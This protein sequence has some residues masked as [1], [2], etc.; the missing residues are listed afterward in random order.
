MPLPKQITLLKIAYD[1]TSILA[2]KTHDV[3]ATSRGWHEKN[4]RKKDLYL[5]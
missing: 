4:P 2:S 5:K 1:S 3:V